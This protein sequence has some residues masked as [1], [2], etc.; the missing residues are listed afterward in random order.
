MK[1]QLSI[2][3]LFLSASF[4]V[5]CTHSAS[6]SLTPYHVSI[7]VTHTG[8]DQWLA[9]YA[10]PP[11][12]KA[13]SFQRQ[14]NQFRLQTWTMLTPDVRIE[15]HQGRE[16]IYSGSGNLSHFDVQF[17]PITGDMIRDYAF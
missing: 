3:L 15:S 12:T 14:R 9:S 8:G 5:S 10:L 1:R 11:G 16:V 17:S 7:S 6:S 13:L 4:L 2:C